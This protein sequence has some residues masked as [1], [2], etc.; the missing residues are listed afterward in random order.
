MESNYVTKLVLIP[1]ERYDDLRQLESGEEKV[2]KSE[3]STEKNPDS[4][5]S[6]E[7]NLIDRLPKYLRAYG[8]K[9]LQRLR[10]NF[11]NQGYLKD[12]PTIHV[13]EFIRDLRGQKSNITQS[14]RKVL[15]KLI[16]KR[17]LPIQPSLIQNFEYFG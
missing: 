7:K 10:G 8:R 4:G 12:A 1:Q 16:L 15:K 13:L 9:I 11:N 17:V 14:N 3:K 6:N 2:I 5:E